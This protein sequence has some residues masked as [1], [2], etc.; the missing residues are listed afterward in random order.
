MTNKL[1]Q[2]AALLLV[3]MLGASCGSNKSMIYLQGADEL[4]RNGANLDNN[5]TLN[6]QPD[7][8]LAIY[9]SSKDEELMKPFT[10]LKLIGTQSNSG[11]GQGSTAYFVVTKDGYIDFPILGRIKAAGMTAEKLSE[12]LKNRM[13]SEGLIRDAQVTT[14]IM[15]FK[16]TVLGDVASP[17]VQSYTGERLTLLE[18]IGRSGDLNSSAIRKKVLVLREENG[19]RTSYTIDLTDPESVF[20]SP[21]YYMHQNDI[22]YVESNKSVKIK[23]SSGYLYLGL[24]GTL[25]GLGTSIASLI[26]ALTK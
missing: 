21:A 2:I 17:G 9:L 22:I 12:D 15:S 13:A 14:K 23:G 6:I 10:N 24:S 16:V 26:I 4:Y 5:Y 20:N 18:A 19:K 7:D 11:G 25:L 3:V 1:K 8:Q